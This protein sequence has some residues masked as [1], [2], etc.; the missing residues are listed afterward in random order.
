MS[1]D[2]VIPVSSSTRF[3][4]VAS[5]SSDHHLVPGPPCIYLLTQDAKQNKIIKCSRPKKLSDVNNK[6]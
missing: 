2:Y 6:S 4:L 1:D 3:Q 5:E